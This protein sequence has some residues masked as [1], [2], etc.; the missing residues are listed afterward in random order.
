M[1][2]SLACLCAPCCRA[3]LPLAA[4]LAAAACSGPSL[5]IA[6]AEPRV[7]LGALV[8]GSALPAMARL[9]ESAADLDDAVRQLCDSPADAKLQIARR[10]W[11]QAYLA[12]CAALPY[13]FGPADDVTMK[14]RLGSWPVNEIVLDHAVASDEFNHM[15]SAYDV[16]GYA[17][18]ELLLFLPTDAGVATADQRC[19]HLIDVTEEIAEL[20]DGVRRRWMGVYGRAMANPGAGDDSIASEDHALALVFAE[21]M[22]V[23]E[24]LLW[25]R[26][27]LPS[28][29][30]RGE[31]APAKLEAV[32][33]GIS[34]EALNETLAA[35]RL[36]VGGS[37]GAPGLAAVVAGI[38]LARAQDMV[39]RSE[40][41]LDQLAPKP[42]EAGEPLSAT[43][44]RKPTR[45]RGLYREVQALQDQLAGT[46]ETLALPVLT[47]QDGD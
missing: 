39:D 14:Q 5:P 28:G 22:N 30:F 8:S 27:G 42:A 12:W 34:R 29:F 23:T 25:Q 43:L 44:R 35:L 32:H 16:R 47:V 13:L 10:A 46:A 7:V 40:R 38:D 6:P 18:A 31:V 20:G 3:G 2:P 17:A 1:I 26:I 11:I 19:T 45:L 15:R 37:A 4:V 33:A 36:L 21:S 24:R 41:A 9:A